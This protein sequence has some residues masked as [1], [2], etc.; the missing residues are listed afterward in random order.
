M[1]A[2]VARLGQGQGEGLVRAGPTG[3][4]QVEAGEALVGQPRRAHAALVPAVA[5]PPFLADPG[6]IL[7]PELDV[8]VGM[9]PRDLLQP[10]PK[11]IF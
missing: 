11:S 1:L 7:A 10:R 4:E 2:V 8:R 5:G 9:S 3:G 6:L